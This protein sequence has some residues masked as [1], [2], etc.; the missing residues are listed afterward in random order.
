MANNA[1][2]L[3][4]WWQAW[5]NCAQSGNV[6]W[7]EKHHSRILETLRGFPFR[8][9]LLFD[10]SSADTLWLTAEVPWLG[11]W[12]QT[13]VDC[14]IQVHAE[15][16]GLCVE[17]EVSVRDGMEMND[18]GG[19]CSYVEDVYRE[20]LLQERDVHA[21]FVWYQGSGVHEFRF[22]NLQACCETFREKALAE[23]AAHAVLYIK[24]NGR[25]DCAASCGDGEF[26]WEPWTGFKEEDQWR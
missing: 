2:Q 15:I 21:L 7:K 9:S 19:F 20:A 10:S 3:A 1:E 6:E 14:T 16:T 11:G 5:K 13:T 4:T 24:R 12:R 18:P 17:C 23:S 25:W 22:E 8:T 26:G